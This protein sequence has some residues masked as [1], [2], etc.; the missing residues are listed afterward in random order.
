MGGE[1][2]KQYLRIG[3]VP[4]L[5]H[6]LHTLQQATQID[7]IILA[8]P[9][10][11][12]DYCKKEIVARFGVNKVRHI[13]AG[14]AQR[15]DSVGAALAAVDPTVELVLVHDAVRPF[16]TID[17]IA[18]VCHAAARHGGAIIAIPVRDTLKAVG[19]EAHIEST[20]DR[21][22]LWQA[23]TPQA[24][25]REVLERAHEKARTDHYIGTDEADLVQRIGEPVV[26]VEGS[27]E[28]I[29]IT[30]PEDLIIGEAIWASRKEAR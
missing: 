25:R 1:T 4:L 2:P 24:F 22:R 5:A 30:R 16:L 21:G 6:A 13:V 19:A 18:R 27:G 15:Q 29:K 9:E 23:Q 17:M 7:H 28:N 8:V 26:V 10:A 11:D 3:G 20:L 12:R 14:G